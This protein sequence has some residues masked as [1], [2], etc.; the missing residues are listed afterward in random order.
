[1]RSNRRY[2]AAIGLLLTIPLALLR[3][4]KNPWVW[5]PVYGYTYLFRGAPLLI[6]LF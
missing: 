1:M 5:T 6:E 3:V 2:S 4:S